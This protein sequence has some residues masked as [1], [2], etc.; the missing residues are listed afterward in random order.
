MSFYH[1][2]DILTKR[3]EKMFLILL[4]INDVPVFNWKDS[5]IKACENF[6]DLRYLDRIRSETLIYFSYSDGIHFFHLYNVFSEPCVPFRINP[7]VS[8]L[9]ACP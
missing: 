3:C 6:Y 4:A 8:T 2:F 1:V 7:N 5:N 9:V